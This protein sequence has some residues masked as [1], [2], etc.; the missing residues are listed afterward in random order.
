MGN[1]STL[2]WAVEVVE[3]RHG[4]D[5]LADLG[6]IDTEHLVFLACPEVA[7]GDAV[8]GEQQDHGNDERPAETGSRVSKLVAELNPVVVDPTT[9]NKCGAIEGSNSVVGEE[10]SEDVTNHTA[11]TVS[12]ED[13]KSIVVTDKVL[14]TSGEVAGSTTENA[15]SDGGRSSNVTGS[16]SDGDQTRDGTGAEA[17]SGPLPLEPPVP[18]HPGQGTDRSSDLGDHH[19]LDSPKV[20]TDGG[21]TVEA[22]PTEPE[23]DSSQ[24]AVSDVV[25]AVSKLLG[26]V[27]LTFAKEDGDG[28]SSGTGGDVDGCTTSKVKTAHLVGPAKTNVPCPV[29][30]GAVDDGDEGESKDQ[31]GSKTGTIS[32]S[33]TS[34]DYRD[35]GKHHLV[36]AVEK[37]RNRSTTARWLHVDTDQTE[38]VQI[39]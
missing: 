37:L 24:D 14:E 7:S 19:S 23:E 15:E 4:E 38:V 34:D 12:S 28:K 31:D 16:R 1:L 39:L 13:V 2:L 27:A 30:D 11:N 36:D 20:G 8:N 29:G 5:L 9:G 32:E 35:A 33:T 3:Q 10:S 21:T 6:K 25:R 18:E 22:E 26:A 17:N